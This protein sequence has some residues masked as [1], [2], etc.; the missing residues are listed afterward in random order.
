MKKK[1]WVAGH[2]GMVGSSL[3]RLFTK[4]KFK[5]L[6]VT[7]NKLDLRNQLKVT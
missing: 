2:T 3:V 6:K 4:K 1:I 7:K 5:L